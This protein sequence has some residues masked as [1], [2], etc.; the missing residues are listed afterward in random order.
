MIKLIIFDWDDVI[1]LGAKDAYFASYHKALTDLGVHLTPD[2]ERKRILAKWSKPAREELKELLKEYPEFIDHACDIYK[3]E[4][5][6]VFL[7]SLSIL[8]GIQKLLLALSKH[9]ILAV[10][11]GNTVD[12]IRNQIMPLFKLPDVFSKIVSSHDISDPEKMKPHPYMLDVIMEA[13]KVAPNEALFV[14][15]AATDVQM[16]RDAGVIPIVVLTGHLSKDEAENLHV[17]LVIPSIMYLPK[18]LPSIPVY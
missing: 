11:S 14:G 18:I 3:K 7:K 16:A 13:F 2:E 9:Y 1:V 5:E 8:P 10:S 15:D 17:K 6:R 4:K 12:I